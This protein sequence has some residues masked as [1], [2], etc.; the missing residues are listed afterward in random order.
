MKKMVL[1]DKYDSFKTWEVTKLSGGFYLRQF[2]NG[3][4]FGKGARLTKKWL[5]HM[6]ETK[7]VFN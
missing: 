6:L 5:E 3:K 2:I 1:V 4:Q 7:L